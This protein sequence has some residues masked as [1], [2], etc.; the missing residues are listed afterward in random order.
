MTA[1]LRS[2]MVS[3]SARNS[4]AL[5]VS[6][7]TSGPASPRSR[8][9]TADAS[10]PGCQPHGGLVDTRVAAVPP[11]QRRLDHHRAEL[12]C[13][14]APDARHAQA[15]RAVGQRQVDRFADAPTVQRSGRL[16]DE[17]VVAI[18]IH[19]HVADPGQGV[20][21]A[22]DRP[23]DQRERLDD[24]GRATARARARRARAT[25]RGSRRPARRRRA[26]TS[27]RRRRRRHRS[28]AGTGR[29][30]ARH[31][32]TTTTAS[33]KLPTITSSATD[34]ATLATTPATAA[35]AVWR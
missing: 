18:A 28:F 33:R 30:A 27:W 34:S 8:S 17:H 12:P 4:P 5:A 32:A 26:A 10:A 23:H 9:I 11:P 24:W 29:P 15:L 19:L 25:R 1:K 2:K 3:D 20:R 14:V 21:C 22:V 35:L 16:A 7:G 31:R 13:V 6:T